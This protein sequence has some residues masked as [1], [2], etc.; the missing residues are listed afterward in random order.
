M[1]Q[2]YLIILLLLTASSFSQNYPPTK[3]TPQTLEKHGLT[4]QDDYSW[5]ERMGTPEVENW[6]DAQ[7]KLIQSH[8]NTISA[9]IF[10]LATLK[11]YQE[12]TNYRV[13]RKFGDYYYSL[14][15]YS[16]EDRQTSSLGYKKSVD[17]NYIELVN[18]NF[19]Y[20]SKTVN[21]IGYTPSK[22]AKFLAYKLMIDGSDQHE[23]RFVTI[24]GG[25]KHKDILKN[26]KFSGMAWKGDEG[27]FYNRNSNTSQFAADSTYRVYYHK[28]GTDVVDDKLIYD[29]TQKKEQVSF[30]TSGDGTLLFLSVMDQDEK[31]SETYYAD[32]KN[33]TIELKKLETAFTEDFSMQGYH[34]GKMFVSTDEA[35]WGDLRYFTLD[36]PKEVKVII[37]QYQNQLL[38]GSEFYENRIVCKYKNLDG[39]YL[40]VFDYDGKLIKK[41]QTPKGMDVDVA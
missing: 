23:V 33:E 9:K 29:A 31:S 16:D 37:P 19:F 1:K 25:K 20:S 13:P 22:Q 41:I 32:L 17:D 7:N 11:K 38:M 26:V 15:S 35:N 3:K 2:F 40:M 30:F 6:V 36:N 21:I 27:I 4:Y 28:L 18:P 24:N 34:N 5:L 12:K 10:P 14:I 8:S 39:S